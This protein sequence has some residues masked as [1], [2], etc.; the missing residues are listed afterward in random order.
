[1]FYAI[2]K[3]NAGYILYIYDSK[4]RAFDHKKTVNAKPEKWLELYGDMLYQYALPRVSD[5]L[6]AEDLVQE[7]FL[8]GLKGLGNYK[9]EASE[10][11]WLFTIL[12]NKIID[13]YRKKAKEKPITSMAD[14]TAMEGGW[15]GTDGSWADERKPRSW[16][17]ADT[18]LETKEIQNIILRCRDN[19]KSLQQFVFT[20]KYMEDR[21]SDEIC[22]VLNITPSYYWVLI[23]RA[24]LQMRECVEQKWLKD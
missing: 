8:S 11:N 6:I 3:T 7:T 12:K 2:I 24:R 16:H 19:L 21:D 18:P 23:H 14:L 15:F 4:L 10:K 5:Q 17:L 9:G 1:M 13:H 22:K 20:L